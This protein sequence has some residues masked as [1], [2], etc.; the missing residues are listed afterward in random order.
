ME[1]TGYIEIYVSGTKGNIELTPDN[2]DIRELMAI[3]ENIEHLI[4]PGDKRNR[5]TI[6]YQIEQGSV[7]HIFK[8]SMQAVIGFNAVLGKI[9]HEKNIDFLEINSGKALEHLQEVAVKADYAFT[10]KTSLPNSNYV[11]INKTTNYYRPKAIWV[12]AEFYFYG[13]IINAGGRNKAKLHV[14]TETG[15]IVINTP[16]SF[17]ENLEENI[18]YKKEYGI[19]ATGKQHSVTGE[20]DS[21]T[22]KFVELVD[23]QPEYDE[24]YLNLLKEKAKKN[25]LN[26][27]NPDAWLREIRG[28]Y[29]A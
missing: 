15:I 25:W 14:L 2:Y 21:S 6:S 12:D 10:I 28:G 3:I 8:T 29:D 18:L 24:T 5:P 1:S 20:V 16:V 26:D 9:D 17:F 27:I 13:K 22:L 23:Y 4:Y 7:R 19:R 11:Q